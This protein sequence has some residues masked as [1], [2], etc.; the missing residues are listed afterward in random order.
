MKKLNEETKKYVKDLLDDYR[1]YLAKNGLSNEVRI[2]FLKEKGLLDP[3][4]KVLDWIVDGEGELMLLTEELLNNKTFKCQSISGKV[5]VISTDYIEMTATEERVKEA[6]IKKGEMKF[7]SGDTVKSP[8]TGVIKNID[9]KPSFKYHND[10]GIMYMVFD[11]KGEYIC[12][13][14]DGKWAEIVEEKKEVFHHDCDCCD[15]KVVSRKISDYPSITISRKDVM[16]ISSETSEHPLIKNYYD[17]IIEY[18][19][20]GNHQFE[21]KN[22]PMNDEQ[23][24]KMSQ[25]QEYEVSGV[26]YFVSEYEY[27]PNENVC[28]VILNTVNPYKKVKP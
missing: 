20:E 11:K 18:E 8:M 24:E 9:V 1:D 7:K 2:K 16:D 13:L 17:N 6:F 15:P 12:V 5:F 27:K 28:H 26:T 25:S 14:I 21:L 22:T 3:K 10:E 4:Y 23:F 19:Q